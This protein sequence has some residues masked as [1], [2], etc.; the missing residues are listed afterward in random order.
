M[1]LCDLNVK[2]LSLDHDSIYQNSDKIS[3]KQKKDQFKKKWICK[4]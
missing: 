1:T 2:N 4:H 3:F